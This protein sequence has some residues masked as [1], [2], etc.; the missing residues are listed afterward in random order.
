M[1]KI[2]YK[3]FILTPMGGGYWSIDH[4]HHVACYLVA[5]WISKEEVREFCRNH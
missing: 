5:A 3:D 2:Y 1:H 4:N